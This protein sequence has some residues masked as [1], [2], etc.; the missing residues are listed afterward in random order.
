MISVEAA[1][2]A[3]AAAAGR[4][5][6]MTTPEVSFNAVLAC[7]IRVTPSDWN[8]SPRAGSVTTTV[9]TELPS[10]PTGTVHTSFS[11]VALVLVS[12][13]AG[14]GEGTALRM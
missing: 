14:F 5:R 2:A 3:V 10:T 11:G 6:Y 7:V 12:T 13:A 1:V 4:G 9:F 8:K